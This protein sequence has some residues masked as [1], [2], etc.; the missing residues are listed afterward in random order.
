MKSARGRSKLESQI[1]LA[2]RWSQEP[3]FPFCRLFI[4]VTSFPSVCI[5]STD[6]V[7]IADSHKRYTAKKSLHR[8]SSTATSVSNLLHRYVYHPELEL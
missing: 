4:G 3:G 5:S 2:Q 8:K 1:R 7:Q 6:S